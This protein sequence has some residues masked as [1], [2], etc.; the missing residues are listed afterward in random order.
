MLITSFKNSYPSS[1]VTSDTCEPSSVTVR[2]GE[3]CLLSSLGFPDDSGCQPALTAWTLMLLSAGLSPSLESLHKGGR[4][5]KPG[6]H[7]PT[8]LL[9]KA[10]ITESPVHS[11]KSVSPTL[12]L[13]PEWISPFLNFNISTRLSMSVP[14]PRNPMGLCVLFVSRPT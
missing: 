2:G 8:P 12:W 11:L 7:F 3:V 4:P 9:S 14:R 13:A 10:R 1:E 6:L 5:V